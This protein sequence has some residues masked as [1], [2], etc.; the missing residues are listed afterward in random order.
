MTEKQIELNDD[1][2][3]NVTLPNHQWNVVVDWLAHSPYQ[4]AKATLDSL[5]THIQI[6][7]DT[8]QQPT[9]VTGT[10]PIKKLNILHLPLGLAPSSV[11]AAILHSL[12]TQRP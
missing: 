7:T 5:N 12:T 6:R 4:D 11:V 10:L 8:E 3:I 9:S 1:C 2:V